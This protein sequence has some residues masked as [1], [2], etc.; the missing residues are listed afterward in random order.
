MKKQLCL[1]AKALGGDIITPIKVYGDETIVD[2]SN[3]IKF[4]QQKYL[5]INQKI[6]FKLKFVEV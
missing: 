2:L 4:V 1:I 6:S 5:T 3:K